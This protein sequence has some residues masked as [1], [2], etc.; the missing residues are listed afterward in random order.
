[1]KKIITAINNP[2]LH[3]ELNKEKNFEIIGKDIQYKE[4]ILDRKSVV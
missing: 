3:E 4:A 1:M 2:K